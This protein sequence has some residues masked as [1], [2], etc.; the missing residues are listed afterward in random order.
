M[1]RKLCLFITLL[2]VAFL[3]KADPVTQQEAQSKALA[4]LRQHLSSQDLQSITKRAIGA[5]NLS[6]A[7]S[8]K[9]SAGTI[10]C[11]VFNSGTTGFVLVA[12]NDEAGGIVG[13]SEEGAFDYA[14]APDVVKDYLKALQ[15]YKKVS[16]LSTKGTITTTYATSVSPLLGSINYSQGTPYNNFCPTGTI[17]GCVATAMAQIMRY[18]KWP[19]TTTKVI[20]AYTTY[21][22]G[23]AISAKPVISFDWDNMLVSYGGSYSSTQATAV[24]TL[25]SYCGTGVYMNYDS[26][27]DAQSGNVDDALI[28]YFGYDKNTVKFCD[29]A[30]YSSAEWNAILKSELTNK[31]PVYYSGATRT[32]GHA[33]VCDGYDATG[34]YHFNW[35]WGGQANGYFDLNALNGW[36][37]WQAMVAGIIPDDGVDS[38]EQYLYTNKVQY[39]S[40]TDNTDAT[41]TAHFSFSYS[42]P[43]AVNMSKVNYGLAIYQGDTYITGDCSH[44]TALNAGGAKYNESF[45]LTFGNLPDGDYHICGVYSF[46]DGVTVERMM[47]YGSYFTNLTVANGVV[48]LS[49]PS[50]VITATVS[51]YIGNGYATA[52]HTLALELN[53]EGGSYWNGAVEL[54]GGTVNKVDSATLLGSLDRNFS[55]GETMSVSYTF[56]YE[57][58]GT[59]YLWLKV[60]GKTIALGSHVLL[61]PFVLRSL[62]P[63]S[64]STES[65]ALIDHPSAMYTLSTS[66]AEKPLAIHAL[67]ATQ[68]G[69][70]TRTLRSE[71]Y[72]DE[73]SEVLLRSTAELSIASG[74]T[75]TV[76]FRYKAPLEEGVY[77]YRIFDGN[78]TL[79]L[80]TPQTIYVTNSTTDFFTDDQQ[81]YVKV[82]PGCVTYAADFA[83]DGCYGDTLFAN[84]LKTCTLSGSW[85]AAALA[86]VSTSLSGNSEIRYLDF[87][88]VTSFPN[89]AT[90]LVLG[91]PNALVFLPETAIEGDGWALNTVIGSQAKSVYISEGAPFES[92]KNF[93]VDYISYIRAF[94]P[95]AGELNSTKE[96]PVWQTIS[97]PFAPTRIVA[98]TPVHTANYTKDK[99]EV[100]AGTDFWLYRVANNGFEPIA[101]MQAGEPY[102]ISMP[103]CWSVGSP[104]T[105]YA[106]RYN[107]AGDVTFEGES[108]QVKATT[109]PTRAIGGSYTLVSNYISLAGHDS[110]YG[111]NSIGSAFVSHEGDTQPFH[112]YAIAPITASSHPFSFLVMEGDKGSL[113]ALSTVSEQDDQLVITSTTTGISI[114][115]PTAQRVSIYGIDGALVRTLS[116]VAGATELALP[117]GLYL[118]NNQKVMVKH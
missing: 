73:T 2:L 57:N 44:S 15:H 71:L 56:S 26:S 64:Y 85:T 54:Y 27:S 48:T 7:Y 93:T 30:S 97:I 40:T 11:Y 10:G 101:N 6:L 96:I 88:G 8:E 105:S 99:R 74:G 116:L 66:Y 102:L 19:T 36:Y 70:A 25:M 106:A 63:V 34:L 5:D 103:Y 100:T 33:F 76:T 94:N 31:R 86:N 107:I 83:S 61:N 55:G 60:C 1:K 92:P 13:Y 17:T 80:A 112:P 115:A 113:T 75:T 109:L 41:H 110:I 23:Y 43:T 77:R 68:G 118:V 50:T 3:V 84:Q 22:K 89:N 81:G 9:D 14:S 47:N 91:N 59:N 58:P 38:P 114:V 39:L 4:F 49:A 51:S 52:N 42:N 87:S 12:G 20:P 18:H 72:K 28:N 32:E 78:D 65:A 98:T 53:N 82:I 67:I 79:K 90:P 62:Y 37:A 95:Y 29:R 46:D 21:K 35:G 117:N 108:V 45:D 24:A 111:L 104:S 69:S 16:T